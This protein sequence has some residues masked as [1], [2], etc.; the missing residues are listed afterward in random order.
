MYGLPQLSMLQ[1]FHRVLLAAH[2]NRAIQ[3]LT[4]ED[5]C[6]LLLCTL[7]VD[8]LKPIAEEL[9]C[10][11]AQLAVAWCASNENVTTVSSWPVLQYGLCA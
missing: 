11:L 7:Q 8:A 5:P 2:A 6:T 1:G 9:G 3:S 4:I 10:T